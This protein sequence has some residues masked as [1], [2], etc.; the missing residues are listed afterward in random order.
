MKHPKLWILSTFYVVVLEI[1]SYK[2]Y[3]WFILIIFSFILGRRM[4][5][6]DSL[7]RIELFH[8]LANIVQNFELRVPDNTEP[9][10][11]D[12]ISYLSLKPVPFKVC[13]RPRN[14]WIS[15]LKYLLLKRK[16]NQRK[17]CF[18]YWKNQLTERSWKVWDPD[19]EL[20]LFWNK[21]L[22]CV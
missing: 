7:T 15:L 2:I 10:S 8:F 5:I 19:Y 22:T 11:V 6:G 16:K 21:R 14:Q 9:P 12:G 1:N 17:Y 4:C 20:E 3:Y 13:I 18:T